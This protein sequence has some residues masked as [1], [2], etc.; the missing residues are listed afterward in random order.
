MVK[1]DNTNALILILVILILAFILYLIFTYKDTFEGTTKE[2]AKGNIDA[3]GENDDSED[4]EPD[5]N[6]DSEIDGTEDA[7]HDGDKEEGVEDFTNFPSTKLGEYN[8]DSS[9]NKIEG[10]STQLHTPY[11]SKN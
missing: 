2:G 1:S 9:Q 8:N 4:E 7:E 5:D 11:P 3:S 6:E 10:F